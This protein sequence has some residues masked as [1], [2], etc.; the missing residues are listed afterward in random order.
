MTPLIRVSTA[1]RQDRPGPSDR[2]MQ[3]CDEVAR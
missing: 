3:L 1:G 2:T